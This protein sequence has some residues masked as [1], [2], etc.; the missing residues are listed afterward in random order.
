[1]ILLA[2]VYSATTTYVSSSAA[3]KLV[4]GNW[5]PYVPAAYNDLLVPGVT[6]G[7][8]GLGG[9]IVT[10]RRKTIGIMVLLGWTTSLIFLTNALLIGIPIPDPLRFLWRLTEP[11]TILGAILFVFWRQD[12]RRTNRDGARDGMVRAR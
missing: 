2:I 6:L 3:S 12:L 7:L 4:T 10:L 8:L 11:L 5:R 9:A 1:M